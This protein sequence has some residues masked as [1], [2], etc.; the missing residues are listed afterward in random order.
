LAEREQ[1]TLAHG[2]FAAGDRER[3]DDAVTDLELGVAAADLDDL[4]HGF[5]AHDVA[6]MHA[7]HES[8][9][10]MEV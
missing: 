10:E 7:W 1:T 9:I 3:N 6:G 5:M 2:A 8:A 4:A